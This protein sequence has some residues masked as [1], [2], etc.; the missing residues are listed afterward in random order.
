MRDVAELLD[1]ALPRQARSELNLSFAQR[2]D[3]TLSLFRAGHCA[4]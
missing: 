3:L 4:P 1:L 2:A